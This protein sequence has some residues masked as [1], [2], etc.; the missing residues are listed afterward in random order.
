VGLV[1]I[2]G[3][4]VALGQETLQ[5][6]TLDAT[7]VLAP[8]IT[9]PVGCGAP[10]SAVT[11]NDAVFFMDET[12]RFVKATPNGVTYL[13]EQIQR[14]LDESPDVSD[15]FGFSVKENNAEYLVWVFP[16]DGRALCY[17]DKVG[18]SQ[19]HGWSGVQW[20]PIPISSHCRRYA[21]PENLV[22]TTDGRVAWLTSSVW[23]DFGE[24]IRAYVQ[25]GRVT[26]G[27]EALKHCSRV[28]VTLRRGHATASTS[29][30]A[31]LGYRDDPGHPWQ[32]LPVRLGVSGDTDPV[33]HFYSLG[34]YRGREWMFEFSGPDELDLV[35]VMEE[36]TE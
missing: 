9:Y 3:Y 2:T 15:C 16:T 21:G 1:E 4:L 26:H 32:K 34:V 19:W 18:W 12:R 20:T 17:Q 30:H 24:P 11:H 27:T 5:F 10:Y 8:I 33:V 31:V 22:G 7:S 35:S 13:S 28:S 14:T 29:P 6:F 25:T 23:T 36:Y